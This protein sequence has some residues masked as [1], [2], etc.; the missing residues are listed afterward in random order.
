MAAVALVTKLVKFVLFFF[1][2][3]DTVIALLASN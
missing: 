2:Y 3:V 1:E